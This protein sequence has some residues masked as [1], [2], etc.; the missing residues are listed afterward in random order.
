MS[1]LKDKVVL[2]TGAGGSIGSEICRQILR[3]HAVLQLV[4]LDNSEL[5]LYNIDR[6]MSMYN[7]II[8]PVL[9]D[10]SDAYDMG[11]AFRR[12]P[13]FVF[14]AAAYKHVRICEENPGPAWRVNVQGTINVLSLAKEI[15]ARVV[16]VSTDK[17]VRPT[18][19]MG[20]TKQRAEAHT[21]RYDQTVI[22]LGN[23]RGSS[24]SVLPLWKEQIAKGEPVTITDPN[25]TRYFISA[26][27]AA[28]YIIEVA[29][30]PP[31][32]YVPDMGK[33]VRLGTL[34]CLH[35]ATN[36]KVIGLRPGEKLHEDLFV[37]S[38][39]SSLDHKHPKIYRDAA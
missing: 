28:A 7:D 13:D 39:L 31:D 5:A 23:V 38:G 34:A 14:H 24:G 15:R 20:E 25:A 9:A 1:F 17:A 35:G 10:V 36:F 29:E 21:R 2:V 6:E 27:Q 3:D 12:A 11:R 37:G 32:T 26:Q 4:M 18:S 22:R 8:V 33:P 19:V 16:L 30:L